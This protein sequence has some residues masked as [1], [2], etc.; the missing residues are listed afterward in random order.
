MSFQASQI[1]S[2][3]NSTSINGLFRKQMRDFGD[4]FGLGVGFFNPRG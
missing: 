3:S 4:I 1:I 2:K